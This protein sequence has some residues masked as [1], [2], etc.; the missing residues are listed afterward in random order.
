MI[1]LS[2]ILFAS[3]FKA[4]ADTLI[5]HYDTSVFKNL[6]PK[7]WNPVESWKYVRFIPLTRYRPDAWHLANSGM[8]F[9]FIFA[10]IFYRQY[11]EWY[12]ELLIAG[13][14][15]NLMFWLW[16]DKLLRKK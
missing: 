14:G 13:V 5:F 16:Y 15:F 9:S 2:L 1:S 7:Y 11:F 6:T 10:V 8:I 12:W 3:F 4:V